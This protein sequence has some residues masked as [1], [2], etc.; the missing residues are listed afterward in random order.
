M[1]RLNA[2]IYGA[3]FFLFWRCMLH[4][5]FL[6]HKASGLDSSRTGNWQVLRWPEAKG[7]FSGKSLEMRSV[8]QSSFKSLWNALAWWHLRGGPSTLP[9]WEGGRQGLGGAGEG[10]HNGQCPSRGRAAASRCCASLRPGKLSL[11]VRGGA[12]NGPGPGLIGARRPSLSAAGRRRRFLGPRATRPRPP[13]ASSRA[14]SPRPLGLWE[15]RGGRKS[16]VGWPLQR[17]ARLGPGKQ[18]GDVCGRKSGNGAPVGDA[19]GRS[20]AS[21][22]LLFAGRTSTRAEQEINTSCHLLSSLGPPNK[23]QR[24]FARGGFFVFFF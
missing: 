16:L 24:Y 22:S 18:R 3:L 15:R 23:R 13:A 2:F 10:G 6:N 8:W 11:G 1:C 5:C 12:D 17:H 14:S 21:R 9:V 19:G 4:F 20:S 7:I